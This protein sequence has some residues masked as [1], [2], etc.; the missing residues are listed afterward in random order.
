MHSNRTAGREHVLEGSEGTKR[1]VT[2]AMAKCNW[3]HLACHGVKKPE[4][5]T[6]S[7]PVLDDWHLTLWGIIQPD[8]PKAEFTF[9]SACQTT[10]REGLLLEEAVYIAA[11]MLLAGYREVVVT[12]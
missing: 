4:D 7:A 2:Q 1:R 6:K 10:T 12:I 3:L 9:L 8:L 11:R 5:P